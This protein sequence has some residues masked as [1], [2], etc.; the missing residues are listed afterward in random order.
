MNQNW[1]YPLPEKRAFTYT[2]CGET[3]ADPYAWLEDKNDPDVLRWVAE[4]NAFTDR[5]FADMGDALARRM[6]EKR[7]RKELPAYTSVTEQ[8]GTLYAMRHAADG[9]YAAVELTPDFQEKRVLLDSAMVDNRMNLWSIFPCPGR[10]ELIAVFSLKHG[11]ARMTAVVRDTEKN[12]T[13]AELDGT[14][15]FAWASD[16]SGI[17]YSDALPREDG[18]TENRLR[19]WSVET[20]EDKVLYAHDG[21]AA[22]GL[23]SPGPEGD[24]YLHVMLNY[25]DTFLVHVTASGDV[26]PF[27]QGNDEWHYIGAVG[28][29]RYFLT[30]WNAPRKRVVALAADCYDFASAEEA[31]PEGKGALEGA[32]VVAGKVITNHLE[33]VVSVLRTFDPA[34]GESRSISQPDQMAAVT[35]GSVSSDSPRLY[36]AFESFTCEPSVLAVE[37]DGAQLV[38]CPD[39]AGMHTGLTVTRQFVPSADGTLIPAFLVHRKDVTATGAVP[40]LMYGYGGYGA[41]TPPASKAVDLSVIDWAEKGGLYVHCVLR[42]GSD[43]GLAW[44]MAGC[45]GNKRHCYEDF[46]A[47]TEKVQS[48]GWTTPAKTAICGMSNGG[49]LMAVLTTMRPDLFGCVLASVPHT[50]MLRFV[51]DDRGPMYITEYGD[52]RTQEL[53]A[54]M[55]SYSPYHNIHPGTAYPP[56]YVQTG[57]MDN[58]VPPYHGKKFAAA[59]QEAGGPNP[60]LLRVLPMGS[61]DRGTGETNLRT[62]SEMELFIE[63]HLGILPGGKQ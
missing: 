32:A 41:S 36:C 56:I 52:P 26:H 57:E 15:S 24:A 1:N 30:D 45:R 33:D 23:V 49:L 43:Y 4:E 20:G 6:E 9:S 46:I 35:L 18:T 42:G 51:F 34:T 5:Y 54:Y 7:A 10:K 37:G 2:M 19:F 13:L 29:K 27:P 8:N 63:R 50:D 28:E 11:A 62:V 44:H 60:V 47:I 40:T 31:I 16:G 61:H 39:P 38:Y 21:H 22:Y 48:D 53:F 12:V 3:I 14:F 58:N 25:H 59:L 17:Y 55:K